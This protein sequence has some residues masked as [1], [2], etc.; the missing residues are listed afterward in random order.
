MAQAVGSKRST[1][2]RNS[3]FE[4]FRLF[5]LGLFLL[6]VFGIQALLASV[7]DIKWEWL[8]DLQQRDGFA[9]WSGFGLA[10]YLGAQW[11]LPL[12]RMTGNHKL[13]KR[14][15][16]LHKQAGVFAPVLF[17]IHSMKFG[18]AFMLVLS[19]VYFA[20]AALGLFSIDIVKEFFSI[21]RKR[22]SFWWMILHVALSFLTMGIM[23]YHIYV[24]FA[25]K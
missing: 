16:P 21:D 1:A 4:K 25:F 3:Q 14:F 15:Y 9:K 19:I 24:A 18:Y 23:F 13:A 11:L 7:L 22:Y 6:L 12:M 2:V 20:N 5:Y 17:Y 10:V 8:Y